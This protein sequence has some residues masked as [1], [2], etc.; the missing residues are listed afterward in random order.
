M[1]GM[2]TFCAQISLRTDLRLDDLDEP[3]EA[4]VLGG[5]SAR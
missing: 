4:N 1:P 3:G 5:Q 2:A